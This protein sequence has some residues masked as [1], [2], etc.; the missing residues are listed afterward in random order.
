[1]TRF[2]MAQFGTEHGHAEG[3][4]I[5]MLANP[6]VEL[7][8]VWEPDPARRAELAARPGPWG[9]VRWF[10]SA[11]ELLGDATIAA[12][13]SEGP[14]LRSLDDTAA[15][16]ASGRHL[17]YDKPAGEDWP[18]WQRL[19]ADAQARGL[20]IQM[21]Y[22][23]RYHPG[24]SRIHELAQSG[25]LGHIYAVR[26][27]MSTSLTVVQRTKIAPHRGGIYYDLAA[28]M[29]DQIV[30]LLGRPDKVTS[31]LR[32]DD[33]GGGAADP[34]PGFV[35]NSLVVMEWPRA[36]AMVDIAAMEPAPMARRYEVYGTLGSAILLEPFEPG[37]RLRLCTSAGEQIVELPAF[38]RQ[39]LYGR[40]LEA[41]LGVLRGER[42]PDR[43]PEHELL[44]QETLLRGTGALAGA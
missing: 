3:K 12:V 16:L 8:G 34:L 38:T 37:Q 39:Q 44:V 1:M 31:F 35:D 43:P 24:F 11:D 9:Q 28:H 5:A 7:A 20:Y 30:W 10:A 33:D 17:W 15:I 18:R 40:E 26:A 23:F 6:Q 2:R 36:L 4:L 42:P 25:A 27:H 13:A 29:L 14:N 32:Q 41:F 22:M 21:G 19:V